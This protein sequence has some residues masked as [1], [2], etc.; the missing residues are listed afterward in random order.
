MVVIQSILEVMTF[1]FGSDTMK[2]LLLFQSVFVSQAPRPI[3]I[4]VNTIL[5]LPKGE[6]IS[7][8]IDRMAAI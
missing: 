4:N 5:T 7:S 2:Y 1:P 6:V 3:V 8:K